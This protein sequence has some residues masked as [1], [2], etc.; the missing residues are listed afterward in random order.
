MQHQPSAKILEAAITLKPVALFT[1]N[2]ALRK[3]IASFR[4]IQF[5]ELIRPTLTERDAK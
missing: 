4:F 2:L 1:Q 3:S 5:L